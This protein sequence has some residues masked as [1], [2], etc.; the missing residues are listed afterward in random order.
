MNS[1]LWRERLLALF[2]AAAL[3]FNFPLLAIWDRDT[4]LGGVPL[5]PVALFLLWLGVIVALA[6]LSERMDD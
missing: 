3:L 2:L 1:A 5:F 4:T 6:L